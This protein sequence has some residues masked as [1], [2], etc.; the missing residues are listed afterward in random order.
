MQKNVSVVIYDLHTIS[1]FFRSCALL[2]ASQQSLRIEWETYRDSKVINA[3][4]TVFFWKEPPGIAVVKEGA[5]EKVERRTNEMH[6][7]FLSTWVRKLSEE[8]P[9]AAQGYVT[10]IG[11][12]RDM[13]RKDMQDFY[14]NASD[15]NNDVIQ[16]TQNG[17]NNLAA[18]KLGAQIGVAAIGAVVGIGFVAPALVGGALTAG[19]GLTILGVEAGAGA[20]AF[21]ATGLAHSVTHSVIKNWDAGAGAQVA[22]IAIEKSKAKA[23]DLA[24]T[25][26]Q[27]VLD[28][29]LASSAN[30][31]NIV[32]SVQG[33][34]NKQSNRLAQQTLTRK[35]AEKASSRIAAGNAQLATRTAELAARNRNVTLARAG[36]VAVPVVFA[37]WD[38]M[39]AISDYRE[40]TA[41]NR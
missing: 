3:I 4:Y 18:I 32:R 25:G 33:E 21:G 40:T 28:K 19:G 41:A 5:P 13:A 9:G 34:I 23:S 20:A 30:A 36:G 11:Q 6:E 37:A 17:I 35:A 15:I 10:T 38:I 24:G 2:L 1:R 27:R 7:R 12:L 16:E 29:A 14:R 26:A 31:E 8:G 39:D 22:G